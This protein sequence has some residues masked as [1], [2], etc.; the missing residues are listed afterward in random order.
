MNACFLTDEVTVSSTAVANTQQEHSLCTGLSSSTQEG[1]ELAG[2]ML[3]Q[4]AT[5]NQAHDFFQ[6]HCKAAFTTDE[7][8]QATKP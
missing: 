6:Q 5:C 1:A 7:T 4:Q 2:M 8:F 3:V